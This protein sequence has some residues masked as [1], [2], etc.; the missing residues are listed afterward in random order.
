MNRLLLIGLL[1]L[2]VGIAAGLAMSGLWM[3]L[4]R[5]IPSAIGAFVICLKRNKGG[6]LLWILLAFSVVMLVFP[7]I[8]FWD[9]VVVMD[10]NPDVSSSAVPIA[11]GLVL[12]ALG[13]WTMGEGK[14]E[15]RYKVAF[16]FGSIGL[17]LLI[18]SAVYT[19]V[20][21][22]L[23][24]ALILSV[25]PLFFI[26]RCWVLAKDGHPSAL[27]SA[28]VLTFFTSNAPIIYVLHHHNVHLFV[29]TLIGLGI[30]LIGES[31]VSYLEALRFPE[32]WE[33]FKCS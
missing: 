31:L 8:L 13:V 2:G 24:L 17:L 30:T 29:L 12:V 3:V 9:S 15:E 20:L 26:W 16:I 6:R 11:C 32:R 33:G 21:H 22:K 18:G 25:I 10:N 27:F 14:V 19:L 28:V 7:S 4:I 1:L 5:C 23:Y